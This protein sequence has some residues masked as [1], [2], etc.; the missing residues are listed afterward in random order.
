[1]HQNNLNFM[2][3]QQ[4]QQQQKREQNKQRNKNKRRDG[5]FFGG[6]GAGGAYLFTTPLPGKNQKVQITFLIKI[7]EYSLSMV[8]FTL[9]PK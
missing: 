5:S 2:L 4:Q 6:G 1:M 8:V 7:L 9:E 3:V